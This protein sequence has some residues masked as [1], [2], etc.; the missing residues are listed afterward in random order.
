MDELIHDN[1]NA[2]D[3]NED[4]H[5]VSDLVS[6]YQNLQED[7][8]SYGLTAIVLV[9]NGEPYLEECINSLVNQTLDNLE[10]LLIN[11]VSTDD[12]LSTCKRFERMYDNVRLIDKEINEGLG[13]NANLG[14]RLARGEYVILVDNDDIIPSYAYEKLY[15]RAK[16]LDADMCIGKANFLIG[17][18]QY[19]FDFRETYVWEE[20]RVFDDV[21]DFPDLFEEVY[22]WNQVVKRDLLIDNDIRLP[23][24]TVYADRYFTHTT[25]TYAKKIA[26]IPDC[27]YLWRQVQSSLSHGRFNLDNYIDRLD[28]FDLDLDY[29]T[30]YSD[31]Y[32]KK[33]LRRFV[34]PIKGILESKEFEDIVFDRVRSLIR[35]YESRYENLYDNDLNLIDNLYVYLISNNHRNELKQLLMLDLK[36]QREVYDENGK[37]YWNLP[38]FRNPDVSIPD[39]LFEIKQ[40]ISEFV[41]IDRIKISNDKIIFSKIRVPRHLEIERFQL[42]FMGLTPADELLKDNL[43]AFDLNHIGENVYD[44]EISKDE[45]S[46]FEMYD[47]FLKPIFKN[48]KYNRLRIHDISIREIECNVDNMKPFI[49]RSGNFAFITQ[50]LENHFKI[51]YDEEK[52]RIVIND[53]ERIKKELKFLVR[54]DSTREHVRFL[55]NE[56]GTAFELD[57][58]YFL[59]SRSSYHLFMTVYN[60]EG[61]IRRNVSFKDKYLDGF[62]E[63][64]LITNDGLD[65]KIYKDKNGNI[66]IESF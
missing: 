48:K 62:E 18:Y 40:L 22:Y 55:L 51:D 37:S 41:S 47:V 17:D 46:D 4:N 61:K 32:F 42:I 56:E 19:E 9:Y 53:K 5:N 23:S 10:I 12:S 57:W 49:T 66:K 52:L 63:G 39:R 24:N 34:I 59:D 58:K 60:D 3:L 2:S 26:I 28:S 64:S 44:I 6:T 30:G 25:Y 21:N 50:N 29:L 20:E 35:K 11:D 54:K 27:V 1:Y 43:L 65:V 14:I 33:L 15:K 8:E 38:L 45:F 31:I 13:A 7:N 16:E 36:H